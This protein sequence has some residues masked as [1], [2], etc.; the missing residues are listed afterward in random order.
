LFIGSSLGVT[1]LLTYFFGFPIGFMINIVIF[2]VIVFYIRR[3]QTRALR[4]FGFNG[5]RIGGGYTNV[6]VKLKYICLL[7]GAEVNGSKCGKCGSTMKKP[8]F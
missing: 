5:E 2:V 6:G 8:I 1:I 7:C 3:G 4:S